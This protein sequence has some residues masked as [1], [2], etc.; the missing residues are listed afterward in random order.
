MSVPGHKCLTL[1]GLMLPRLGRLG[2]SF[3][4]CLLASATVSI[5]ASSKL[6]F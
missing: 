3:S 1:V 6:S 5:T 4:C 2:L